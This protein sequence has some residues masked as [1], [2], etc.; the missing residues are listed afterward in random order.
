MR[1]GVVWCG[2]V[3]CG[4]TGR[5]SRKKK[6]GNKKTG[7]KKAKDRQETQSKISKCRLLSLLAAASFF[8][9]PFL[10]PSSFFD[11]HAAERAQVLLSDL[12][13]ILYKDFLIL[14]S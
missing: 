10:P 9:L 3:R 4:E 14:D 2:V 7:A 12:V 6:G 1:C 8:S 5:W 13:T 11:V